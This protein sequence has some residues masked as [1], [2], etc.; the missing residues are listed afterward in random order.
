MQRFSQHLNS[1]ICYELW[2][3]PQKRSLYYSHS[4]TE[5]N[6]IL[7][8]VFHNLCPFQNHSVG[9]RGSKYSTPIQTF[10]QGKSSRE[11]LYGVNMVGTKDNIFFPSLLPH[12]YLPWKSHQCLYLS[13]WYWICELN[14]FS[15]LT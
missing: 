6:D 4:K 12:D 9:M 14:E 8:G 7:S 15:L 1:N 3:R 10:I 5:Y 2:R 13:F 11:F